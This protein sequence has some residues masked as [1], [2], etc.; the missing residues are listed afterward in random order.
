MYR[1]F[2]AEP[3]RVS[4]SL[5]CLV[6]TDIEVAEGLTGPQPLLQL[7]PG[8]H[9]SRPFHEDGKE[10]RGLLLQLDAGAIFT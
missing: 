3:S 4:R 7:F 10:I 6:E 5:D 2:C 1:G 8:H 9:P